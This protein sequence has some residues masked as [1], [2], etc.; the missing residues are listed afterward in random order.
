V[1]GSTREVGSGTFADD[2]GGRFLREDELME[3][4]ARQ[5]PTV[6]NDFVVDWSLRDQQ[7][8]ERYFVGSPTGVV[9]MV[10]GESADDHHMGD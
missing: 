9:T 2:T 8:A 10:S 5:Q 6:A 1:P 7:P 3:I 4:P